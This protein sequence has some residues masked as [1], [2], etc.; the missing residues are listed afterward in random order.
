M[1]VPKE[2]RERMRAAGNGEGAREQGIAI[3][4]EAL[5]ACRSLVQGVYIMPP[6]GRYRSAL[7]VI[8]ALGSKYN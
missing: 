3:A 1:S 5:L 4:Q 7:Q 2:V 8:E 6:L